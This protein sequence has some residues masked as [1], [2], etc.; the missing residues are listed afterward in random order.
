MPQSASPHRSAESWQAQSM[1]G[2]RLHVH[3]ECEDS[4]CPAAETMHLLTAD[5]HATHTHSQGVQACTDLAV[6]GRRK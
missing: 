5:S 6:I 3:W 4:A 2:Q 1:P